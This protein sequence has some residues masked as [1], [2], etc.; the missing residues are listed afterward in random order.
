VNRFVWTATDQFP[1]KREFFRVRLL[2]NFVD[3]G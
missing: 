3:I 1:G 2:L